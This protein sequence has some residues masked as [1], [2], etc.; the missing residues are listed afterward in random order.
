MVHLDIEG[1]VVFVQ[2]CCCGEGEVRVMLLLVILGFR[3]FC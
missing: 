1:W 3:A 2:T